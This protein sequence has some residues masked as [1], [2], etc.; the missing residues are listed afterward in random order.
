MKNKKEIQVLYIITKLELG[1]AQ[2]VCISLFDGIKSN[3][4][5]SFLISGSDGGP[6]MK[7]VESN[8]NAILL[9]NLKREV[10]ALGLFMEIKNFLDLTKQIRKIKRENPDLIVHTHSTKAGLVGRWA[11]LFAGVKKRV[12]T[13]HGFGFHDHQNKIA[14]F[15]NYFLELITSFITTH[16]VCV[17]CQDVKTGMKLFPNFSKKNSIIRAAVE[18]EKFYIPAKKELES[19]INNSRANNSRVNYLQENKQ[20][21]IFGTIGCFKKQ[22][23]L[24]DLFNAFEYAY[25]Q[26]HN[27]KLEIL[28]DGHL[29]PDLEK[30]ILEHDL[31]NKIIL[32]GWQ[33]DVPSFM[34]NWNAYVMSSLWEGLPCAIIE[35]R[36]LKLPV[37]CY[38]TGGIHEVIT[39]GQ[40]GFLYPQKNWKE[41]ACGM[42]AISKNKFLYKKMQEHED[43]L[44]DF[45]NN[46]MINNH[47]D[48]YKNL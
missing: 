38:K 26:N 4:H 32:H 17:S 7:K 8:P 14:W 5:E 37:L 43:D 41:L 12:H 10:S 9:K 16:Y 46:N 6:L 33:E 40:N 3:G 23:N 36:L 2:K 29:R 28:G 15:I 21:F 44:S 47:I 34:A 22:K 11:A 35:A 25:L 27:I 48:L 39:N 20:P 45:N 13:V 18:Y 1:G 19:D 30:W 31:K 42:L 24:F